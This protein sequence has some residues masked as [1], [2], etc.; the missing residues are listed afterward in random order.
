MAR[1]W[2]KCGQN[3]ANMRKPVLKE[4]EEEKWIVPA[5]HTLRPASSYTSNTTNT[6]CPC[7]S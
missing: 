4:R 2:K 3:V 5:K 1:W 6:F 7:T